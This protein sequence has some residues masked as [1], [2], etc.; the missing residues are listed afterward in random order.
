M[1]IL[2]L[3]LLLLIKIIFSNTKCI[4]SKN[5][6]RK[7]N[8]LTNNC[9]I[10]EIKEVLL[11]DNNG[12]CI[13]SKKCVLG[14]NYCNRCSKNEELCVICENNYF[15]DKNGGCSNSDRCKLSYKGKCFECTDGFFLIGENKMCKYIF[16][17]DFKNCQKIDN[18]LGN[19][20]IC[21]DNY[22]LSEGDKKCTKTENCYET[23]LGKCELCNKGFYFDFK[24]EKCFNKTGTQFTLCQQTLDGENCDICDDGLYF[25]ENN[26]CTFSNFC[27]ESLDG[28]CKKCIKGYY[29]V[30]NN[31]C[32]NEE[33]C[34]NADKDT[35]ICLLCKEHYF[36]DDKDYK[37]KS[38][39][40]EN[41]YKYC[42]KLENNLCTKCGSSYYLGKDNRC[43][44]TKNCEESENGKCILCSEN[45]YL[46]YDGYCLN[47][48]HCIYTSYN[49]ECRECEDNYYYSMRYKYCLETNISDVFYGCKYSNFFEEYC[50]ECKDNFYFNYNNSLCMDNSGDGPLYKCAYSDDNGELCDVC[51]DGYYLGSEDRKC[52]LI[53]NCKKSEN[54]YICLECEDYYCLDVKNQK[55]IDNGFLEDE[56]I[57]IYFACKRTN[58]KGTLCEEC[59]DGYEINEEG[60]CIDVENCEERQE[61][62]KCIRCKSKVDLDGYIINYCANDIFGCVEISNKNCLQCN[63]LTELYT[64]TKCKEGYNLNRY[65]ECLGG[66]KK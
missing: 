5:Y 45:Y 56:N 27:S 20:E 33:N 51:I 34:L 25:D 13:G 18:F 24:E 57:K 55:C 50:L 66:Y 15:P 61:D 38:N 49:G 22:F 53:E 35:G 26:L 8:L 65:G 3:Y 40:D 64:C 59:I 30:N 48:E 16:S 1:N 12:G 60:Y 2:Y 58:E 54:E 6:C 36:L 29:L 28:N 41:E 19:C 37:C 52:S 32:S 42:T 21:E 44:Y 10:C 17:D 62:G 31:F 23:I 39:L 47:V 11:P 46:T 7:C 14:K 9:E 4:E 43:S 63:N